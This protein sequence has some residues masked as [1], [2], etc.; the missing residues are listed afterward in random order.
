MIPDGFKK[1]MLSLLGDEE[2]HLLENSMS[3]P[4]VQSLRLNILKGNEESRNRII[5]KFGLEP[6]SYE[7]TGYYFN[8]ETAPGRRPYHDAGVYYIQDPG[9]MVPGAILTGRLFG[10]DKKC[11]DAGG[12]KILDL[13]AA[14][15]G[16]STQIAAAMQ[17][18][19]I[20]F[21][22]E[23]NRSR[24]EILS[25]NIERM[26]IRNAIVLNETSEKLAERFEGYFD[27]IVVDAPCSGEGMFRKDQE[28]VSQWSEESVGIC[29]ERQTDIL[30]NACRMLKPGGVIVYSTCTFEKE[31]DE[32]VVRG[33]LSR[34]SDI[35]MTDTS[36]FKK[37]AEGV[38]DGFSGCEDAVR[39]WPM[40][41]RG[42][43]HFAALLEKEGEGVN[44]FPAGG[45]EDASVVRE[46]K[47]LESFLKESLS[48]D[49][50][51][52]IL[53]SK[54]RFRLFGDNLFVMP[55]D[56]PSLHGLKV[57]RCGLH[58]G[59]F[60]KDR[61]EPAH[62]LALS[63]NECDV[64][65]VKNVTEDEAESFVK[66]MTLEGDGNGWVLISLDGFSLGWG[67]ASG[68]KIKNHYPK[69]LRIPG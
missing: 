6:V 47:A 54:D 52:R 11:A 49:A 19:G 58:L 40:Y 28:A 34:H 4:C 3:E 53:G 62:A 23:I 24:A 59:T 67:K 2:Y 50:A 15:G 51:S 65:N 45:Y 36:F 69:G 41:F 68:G 32:D 42:E 7:K 13:C 26:G 60:K 38:R 48:K 44:A 18:K 33:L 25:R 64:K 12:L 22:N 43:G 17:G 39:I 9:A 35:K 20:L 14:P 16:K 5:E 63:L 29:A 37:E 1:N 61:F 31:E 10:T 56:T 27:A 30:E 55:E 57:L 21:S 8:P 66:G 46:L